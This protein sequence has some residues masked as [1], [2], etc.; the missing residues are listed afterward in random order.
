MNEMPD[1]LLAADEP[2][3]V[4]VYNENGRSPFLIVA[5]HAGNSMPRAPSAIVQKLLDGALGLP[6]RP[7]H[8][9]DDWVKALE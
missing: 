6:D 2:A 3:P 8:D 4:T 5:D 7:W 9:W 1:S